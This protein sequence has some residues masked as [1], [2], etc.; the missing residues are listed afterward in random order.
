MPKI[1]IPIESQELGFL[2]EFEELE[3]L[4]SQRKRSD[5]FQYFIPNQK[6]LESFQ[7]KCRTVIIVAGNRIGK[8]TSGC[9]EL[10]AHALGR[11]PSCTCHGA[12]IAKE[13]RLKPPIKAVIVTTEYPIIERAI[14]PT[15]MKYL[16]L[17]EV[18]SM[19]RTPQ[20]YL[21]RITFKNG[22]TVDV[23]T[24]E[25]DQLAFESADWDFAWID[26]PTQKPKYDAIT[27]GLLDRGGLSRITFTPIVEPW[28]KEEL[29]DKEDKVSIEV[30]KATTYDNTKDIHGNSILSDKLIR[31]WE[32]SLDSESRKTRIY[33]DFFHVRG[34][35]YKEYSSAIHEKEFTYA[36]P[37]SNI[38]SPYGYPDPVIAVLDPHDRLPHHVIWAFVDRMDNLY[39][40]RELVMEGTVRDLARAILLTEQ[41]SGYKMA[42][43]LID[44]NF[45]MKP[46]ITTGRTVIQELA[47]PPFVV[48]FGEANDDKVAGILKV[49][50]YLHFN[51]DLPL[52]LTNQPK[53]YFSRERCPVTIK[54]IRN[55]QYAEWKGNMKYERDP[56]EDDKQKDTHGSDCTRYLCMSNPTFGRLHDGVGNRNFEL[57]EVAY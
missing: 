37:N 17:N 41:K 26:E 16:P 44:P 54:S 6:Q 1:D 7:S 24:N 31:E 19:Q 11:Y 25:M 42:R 21:R 18:Q 15:L 5:G 46:L 47:Q 52:G 23:L 48:R 12:W 43:R 2:R 49:K 38:K 13:R 29:V 8:T 50:E 35:V 27:R 22:S 30:I 51:P 57:S 34:Q 56:K 36:P 20:R 4:K 28:M 39:V 32:A 3:R 33:G 9:I 14:E 45:G 55:Y 10:I 40:D 53:L